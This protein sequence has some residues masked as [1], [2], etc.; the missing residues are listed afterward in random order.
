MQ[1]APKGP[2]MA[3][4]IGQ[5]AT[6]KNFKPNCTTLGTGLARTGTN[7]KECRIA[8]HEI[9]RPCLHSWCVR[10]W[11]LMSAATRSVPAEAVSATAPS[12]ASIR[13]AF[14][15]V[16]ALTDEEAA[17]V[18]RLA[19]RL[20][21]AA[22]LNTLRPEQSSADAP[23]LENGDRVRTKSLP[24]KVTK[25][26][27][28][29]RVLSGSRGGDGLKVDL[30]ER[31]TSYLHDSAVVAGGSSLPIFTSMALLRQHVERE[32]QIKAEQHTA[33]GRGSRR[34]SG[35]Q[36]PK[37]AGTREEEPR[38]EQAWS[39]RFNHAVVTFWTQ[40]KESI[41]IIPR[42]AISYILITDADTVESL[43]ISITAAAG[44]CRLLAHWFARCL[45]GRQ[46]CFNEKCCLPKPRQRL[47]KAQVKASEVGIFAGGSR[48]AQ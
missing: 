39:L 6:K 35:Q 45:C 31:S 16:G 42:Q 41:G 19:K 23:M 34:A 10:V 47:L 1:K 32:Q 46:R 37:R 12:V 28:A 8:C 26:D 24:P 36:A 30:L 3:T 18:P 25:D 44:R 17:L 4:G 43:K 21:Y 14:R 9:V 40:D 48:R 38:E 2:S 15:G 13:A 7:K 22:L 29:S 27:T 33:E 20:R 5:D 11:A